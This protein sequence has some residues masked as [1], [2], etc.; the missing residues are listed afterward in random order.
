MLITNLGN[1]NIF[2]IVRISGGEDAVTTTGRSPIH[3]NV[4][5]E[6]IAKPAP[7]DLGRFNFLIPN[8]KGD[9]PSEIKT[10]TR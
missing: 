2:E 4:T 1:S 8:L 5:E 9:S 6:P 3:G 7:Y 10:S